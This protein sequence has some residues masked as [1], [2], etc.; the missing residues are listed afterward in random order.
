MSFD[1]LKADGASLLAS[2]DV[3][4]AIRR[5]TSCLPLAP[6]DDQ[7]GA[8]QSNLSLCFLREKLFPLARQAAERV[9]VLRPKWEKGYFRLG[10]VFFETND[11]ANAGVAYKTALSLKPGDVV[12]K[13]RLTCAT[14]ASGSRFYFRQLLPGRDIALPQ[15]AVG[16]PVKRQIFAAATQMKNFIYVVGDYITKEC[17]VIDACW[18][19]DGILAVI[20]NDKMKLTGAIATHYHFDHVGGKPPA[21]FDALGIVVPGLK[22]ISNATDGPVYCHAEDAGSIAREA[23]VARTR[24]T[25]IGGTRGVIQIG[26]EGFVTIHTTHTPGHSPGSM[27]L[28]VDGQVTGKKF[29]DGAGLLIS[30]DT[31]FPGSCGRLDLPDASADR[32]FDS[33][34]RVAREIADDVD[35]FPGHAYAGAKSTIREE[36]KH[37]LLK[38]FTKTQW[39]AMH[40]R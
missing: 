37:G 38:P 33:L 15:S 21:P 9:V 20:H 35:V 27:V 23:G 10:E 36:K 32:M 17:F 13:R 7:A 5:Y 2:G 22:Q 3:A 30:G 18:D 6:N 29:G 31:I 26:S 4:G 12:I 8:V 24:L 25:E 11:F 14:E 28:F 34:A 1:E 39:M 16:D 40:Q 19:V